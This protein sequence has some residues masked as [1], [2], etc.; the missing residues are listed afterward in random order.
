MSMRSRVCAFLYVRVLLQTA[1]CRRADS[2]D[3]GGDGHVAMCAPAV[4]RV[5]AVSLAKR[6]NWLDVK[7]GEVSDV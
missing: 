6:W 4:G 7:R 3:V 5:S 1:H 2:D